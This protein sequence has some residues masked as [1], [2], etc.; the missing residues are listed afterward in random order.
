MTMKYDVAS[1]GPGLGQAQTRDSVKLDN[2]DNWIS[3]G[4]TYTND[5]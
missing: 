5:G 1:P 2:V 3:N 4:N